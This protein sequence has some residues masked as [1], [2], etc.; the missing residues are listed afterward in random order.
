MSNCDQP[1]PETTS[2]ISRIA[3]YC[4]PSVIGD[5][6]DGRLSIRTANVLTHVIERG[7]LKTGEVAA[8]IPYGFAVKT[9]RSHAADIRGTLLDLVRKGLLQQ[10]TSAKTARWMPTAAATA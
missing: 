10:S 5:V 9:P 8:L 3:S 1:H 6:R 2:A 7:N 4:G